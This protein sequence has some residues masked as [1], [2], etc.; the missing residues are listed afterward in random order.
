MRLVNARSV[1]DQLLTIEINSG[2]FSSVE[3]QDSTVSPNAG[4]VD[5]GGDLVIPGLVDIHVHSRDPG[6]THKEDWKSLSRSAFKG[7]V[8]LVC[9][10]PNTS[11]PTMSLEQVKAKAEIASQGGVD[12]RFYMGV[13]AANIDALADIL[14]DLEH[15]LCGLKVYYGQSTGELMY[16]DLEKLASAIPPDFK[17]ILAFHSEDQCCI[18]HNQD[19]FDPQSIENPKGFEVHSKIRSSESAHR[20]TQAILDWGLK[21]NIKIHI[22]HLSTPK[23]IEMI[24]E[25]R[26]K[27]LNATSEVAPHH[28]VFSTDDYE[29]LG[30]LIKMNPPVRSPEEVEEMQRAFGRGDIEVFATDH[31]PHTRDEKAEKA[32]GRCPSGVPAVEFFAPML[33]TLAERYGLSLEAG[34]RMGAEAPTAL[35]GLTDR[36]SI[37]VGKRADLVVL[38]KGRFPISGDDIASKCGWTPYEGMEMNYRVLKTWS[39]GVLVFEQ[40]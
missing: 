12:F 34:V 16:D 9:D 19:K 30:S 17:G 10:M 25:A 1:E 24:K 29:R 3:V 13:G 11:P 8:T 2:M 27:G 6:H 33:L 7:G 26:A 39:N 35:L 4:E 15:P 32:Y 20:S 31:A 21:H 14:K 36:G 5:L 23:E 40:T 22:A 18:D 38:E 28:L 37:E